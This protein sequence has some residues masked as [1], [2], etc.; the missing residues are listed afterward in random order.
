MTVISRSQTWDSHI[1]NPVSPKKMIPQTWT[2]L[3]LVHMVPGTFKL[4]FSSLT[5]EYLGAPETFRSHKDTE[6]A[7]LQ[8]T[9][10]VDIWSLGCVF[11]EG[12]VWAHHGWKRVVEY[13]RRR[14]EEIEYKGGNAGE[15]I[16]HFDGNLLDAVTNIHQDIMGELRTIDYMT[17][18]VLD[19][20]VDDML[21]HETRPSAKQ[22]F[23]KSQRLIKEAE[24]R[25]GVSVVGLVGNTNGELVDINEARTRTKSP[26]H[27]PYEHHRS[28]AER[29]L[30]LGETPPP[31]SD[32]APSSSTSS[33]QSS[34]HR[35]HHKSTSQSSKPHRSRPRSIGATESSQSGG[36]I[37]YV[38][39]DPP[40]PPSI[41]ANT[42]DGSPQQHVQQ[43]HEE[44]VR[45]TLSINEGHDW[46]KEKKNGGLAVLPGEENL[47]S[48]DQRDHVSHVLSR[49]KLPDRWL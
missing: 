23:E 33:S 36:K 21:Q 45:P 27:V 30:P 12:S 40:T 42:H 29:K 15:H 46:K 14:S 19:R 17:R 6:S 18:S 43:R 26:P 20:L 2:P 8:V 28:R 25:F 41:A 47:T 24:T 9:Q 10:A 16:F 34:L 1:S 35:H 38:E 39:P 32:S 4:A 49:L 48:L 3:V 7:P 11:S 5:D 22:I 31:D 37:S 13:R 44:P